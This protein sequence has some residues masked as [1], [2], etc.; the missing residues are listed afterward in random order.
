MKQITN[1]NG[2]TKVMTLNTEPSKTH[3]SFKNEC[4]INQ[5][6]SKFKKTGMVTHLAKNKGVYMDISNAPDYQKALDTVL[7]A[8]SAFMALPSQVRKE[9]GNDPQNLMDLLKDPKNKKRA[10]ELGLLNIIEPTIDKMDL[11]IDEVKK[12]NT[13][14][15]QNQKQNQ[16]QNTESDN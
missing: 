15:K 7:K 5:I 11:L 2:R 9:L 8:E 3:Q 1:S 16:T 6:M 13:N 4:D 12:Q 10:E 14:K